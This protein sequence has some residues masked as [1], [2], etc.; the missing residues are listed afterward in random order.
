[1]KRILFAAALTLLLSSP[2][3]TQATPQPK[4]SPPT[5]APQDQEA[6]LPDRPSR[7]L[8][9]DQVSPS[10][11]DQ[12]QPN[13]TSQNP[14]TGTVADTQTRVQDALERQM[15][16]GLGDAVKVSIAD[17]GSLQLSGTVDTQQQKQRAEDIARSAT[18]N[19]SIINKI[20]VKNQQMSEPSTV[21]K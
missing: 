8:P 6:P 5:T 4:T 11:P 14:P 10:T 19:Q 1:M 3:W 7:R 15:P 13:S 18:N 20:S 16:A 9:P 21:P 17:D 2:A 12:T